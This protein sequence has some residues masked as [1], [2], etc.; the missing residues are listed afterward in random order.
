MH[1]V[2]TLLCAAS[3]WFRPALK[4]LFRPAQTFGLFRVLKKSHARCS[5]RSFILGWSPKKKQGSGASVN[6][7]RWS[8][9]RSLMWQESKTK[10]HEQEVWGDHKYQ[11]IASKMGHL[12]IPNQRK[13]PKMGH[14]LLKSPFTHVRSIEVPCSLLQV[15]WKLNEILTPIHRF[16]A[17]QHQVPGRRRLLRLAEIDWRIKLAR[18]S[19]RNP[20]ASIPRPGSSWSSKIA[21][22]DS[23]TW[24]VQWELTELVNWSTEPLG[25][26]LRRCFRQDL[27]PKPPEWRH[28][29]RAAPGW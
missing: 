8:R 12:Q 23:S 25:L 24:Q 9:A 6:G 10:K 16:Q 3:R 27:Q 2:F 7:S 19:L 14:V 1:F 29:S 15:G 13:P 4:G 17:W 28:R 5:A 22:L 18:S 26:P 11:Q 21:W 20:A